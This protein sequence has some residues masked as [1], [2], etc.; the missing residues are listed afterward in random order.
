MLIY[1]WGI[2]IGSGKVRSGYKTEMPLSF[3][4]KSNR[5]SHFM[6]EMA[7]N[8]KTHPGPSSILRTTCE[9]ILCQIMYLIL[10]IFVVS[11]LWVVKR[12]IHNLE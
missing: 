8:K 9:S 11:S 2:V 10:N 4:P 3:K 12:I 5:T 6:N 7:V 1:G